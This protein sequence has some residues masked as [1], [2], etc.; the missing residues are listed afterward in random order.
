GRWRLDIHDDGRGLQ[1]GLRDEG[2]IAEDGR[3]GCRRR[4]VAERLEVRITRSLD[5]LAL[6]L[7]RA[8]VR[9]PEVE[10]EAVP[11]REERHLLAVRRDGRGEEPGIVQ[12]LVVRQEIGRADV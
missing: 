5:Q 11:L 2:E 8:R 10:E 1:Y 6:D 4:Q 3:E 7:S 9:Q 12:L